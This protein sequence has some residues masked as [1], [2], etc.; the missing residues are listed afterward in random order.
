MCLY[1]ALPYDQNSEY[2]KNGHNELL[3]YDYN[4]NYY[5]NNNK[6]GYKPE[7]SIGQKVAL[8]GVSRIKSI[9]MA[10]KSQFIVLM[11][12]MMTKS[13]HIKIWF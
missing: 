13:Q 1:F 10:T 7:T 8:L 5:S 3:N 11:V 2:D 6:N 12:K 4:S 9:I